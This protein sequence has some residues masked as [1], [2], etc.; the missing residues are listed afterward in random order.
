MRVDL[1]IV[2]GSLAIGPARGDREPREE[3]DYLRELND[4]GLTVSEHVERELRHFLPPGLPVS[5]AITFRRGS[6]EFELF[7]W[8][9]DFTGNVLAK[10]G[11]GKM[12]I[13][14]I[15]PIIAR[16]VNRVV[17][18]APLIPERIKTI[19]KTWEEVSARS[20]IAR[21]LIGSGWFIA[22]LA[23]ALFGFYL[24]RGW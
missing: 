4:N 20:R 8:I 3:E 14:A 12:L 24:R 22:G 10:M 13:A 17:S 2:S 7:L 16:A 15:D 11:A 9:V 21:I 19:T 18:G 1:I 6:I 5:A 23:V